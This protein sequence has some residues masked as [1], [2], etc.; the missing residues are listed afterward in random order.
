REY[1]V[2]RGV[3]VHE[4]PPFGPPS[5]E[6]YPGKRNSLPGRSLGNIRRS[7]GQCLHPARRLAVVADRGH[8]RQARSPSECVSAAGAGEGETHKERGGFPPP[9]LSLLGS[10]LGPA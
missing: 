4:K 1:F 10:G 2:F 7:R 3:L 8:K 6:T 9:S 5:A